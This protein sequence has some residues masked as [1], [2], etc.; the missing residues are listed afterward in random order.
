VGCAIEIRP[1]DKLRV[2][3]NF[4]DSHR[5][6]AV[7]CICELVDGSFLIGFDYS[8][9]KRWNSQ[10]VHLQTLV[11]PEHTI[12]SSP[13]LPTIR[14]LLELSCN[15]VVSATSPYTSP[16]VSHRSGKAFR[17]DF[18]EWVPRSIDRGVGGECIQ[19]IQG[20]TINM[21]R[22]KSWWFGGHILVRWIEL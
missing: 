4:T 6:G 1:L 2:V 16:Y 9:L 11:H 13:L 5:G 18:C 3:T 12:Y 7:S 14:S 17:Q 21:A 8:I 22:L 19:I 10:S 20:S 15:I